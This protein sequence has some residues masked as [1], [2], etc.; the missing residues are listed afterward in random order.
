MQ[1]L[2]GEQHFQFNQN[3]FSR[4]QMT[5]SLEDLWLVVSVA[6]LGGTYLSVQQQ[7]VP[8]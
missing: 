3:L 2:K 7:D 8:L 4:W 1:A 5:P 6:S